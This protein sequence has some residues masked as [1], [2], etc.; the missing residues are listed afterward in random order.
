MQRRRFL[1]LFSGAL[2][3]TPCKFSLLRINSRSTEPFSESNVTT[4]F[5]M[6]LI[7]P[8]QILEKA[9]VL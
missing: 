1:Q 9:V 5:E 3:T 6:I 2:V 8:S 7:E 4:R